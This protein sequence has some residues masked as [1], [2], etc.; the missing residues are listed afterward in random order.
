MTKKTL[1][2][3]VVALCLL[4][5][6][7]LSAQEYQNTPVTVSAEK[8]RENGKLFYSHIV[9]E[10][11][12]LF[13]IAKAYGVSMQEISN[14]NPK[15]N[16]LTEGPKKNQIIL[17]PI[18]DEN[19][20]AAMKPADDATEL[21]AAAADTATTKNKS[22][23]SVIGGAM[24]SAANGIQNAFGDRKSSTVQT[25]SPESE[26][27]YT[28]HT[29]KWYEDLGTIADKYGVSKETIITFNGL[30]SPKVTKGMKLKIPDDPST[31]VAIVPAQDAENPDVQASDEEET[32]VV[33]IDNQD[34]PEFPVE[35][36]YLRAALLLPFNAGTDRI[37]DSNYDFY[38]GA[39]LALKDLA[40]VGLNVDL[41]VYDIS[42][43]GV[44]ATEEIYT[45]NDI[46]LGPI[47]LENM[48]DALDVCPADK[49]IISP[50]DPKTASLAA[51]T[52]N[53]IQAPSTADSQYNDLVEWIK[54]EKKP[55][56]KLI[57]ISEK[58][59][60][61]SPLAET[62]AKSGL[63]YETVNYGILEGRDIT[64][65]LKRLMSTTTVN[66]IVIT[67]ESEA[68]VNDVVRNLNIM[69]FQKYDVVLYGP[70]RIRNFE[71]IEVENFHNAK[72]HVSSSYFIDYD[73]TKVKRFLMEY[74]A[75]YGAEPTPFAY[76][77]YDTAYYFLQK[78]SKGGIRWERTLN[79]ERFKGLQSDF[80]FN[81]V[82][83]GG[84][85]NKAVRRIIYEGD[86]SIK[87]VN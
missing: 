17:I 15:L 76:Q 44:L 28:I 65:L 48:N 70:S 19:T 62:I 41:S 71:T 51:G 33:E 63:E 25:G 82:P 42:R 5:C 1:F 64:S 86:Y 78:C 27:G 37:N 81:K 74:R 30:S 6:G 14:A 8:V 75:L 66:R 38:S 32:A 46:I 11:Q 16:L 22:I 87:M 18:K 34:E 29:V 4:C 20:V 77:G 50:L 31:V 36:N 61:A 69:V 7:T 13:S 79:Q 40:D 3:L 47:S 67:S 43:K 80:L 52:P 83:E 60:A 53:F 24:K 55:E 39:L 58:N 54:E 45:S 57:V 12:T 10:K 35:R 2:P 23:I 56:D 9:L 85:Y 73:N 84:Y 72:L 68:F 59:M 26:P 49:I 21:S